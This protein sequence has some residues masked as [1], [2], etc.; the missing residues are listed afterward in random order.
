MN[1]PIPLFV[2]LC[3][4]TAAMSLRLHKAKARPPITRMGSKAGY[5]D[6]ILRVLGVEP[7]Q[8][9][10]RYLWCEPDD[11]VRL[12][13]HCYQDKILAEQ[14]AEIIRSWI[15]F[16]AR[17][18]WE[19]LKEEGPIKCPSSDPR[20]AARLL[21]RISV[22]YDSTLMRGGF[23]HPEKG[24][25]Y[26]AS[27]EMV[28]KRTES[29]VNIA[30]GVS[31]IEKDATKVDPREVARWIRVVTSNTLINLDPETW[32]N[33][34]RGG[35]TF[36]GI[37]CNP[38]S[39]LCSRIGKVDQIENA[40][41][42]GKA[43]SPE[44]SLPAG[45]VCYMD[46]PYV[47]TTPYAH[48]LPRSEVVRLAKAWSEA[49][50]IVCI[51]EAEPIGELVAEGWYE[52]EISWCRTGIGTRSFSKQQRE[53]LTMNIPGR[54]PGKPNRPLLKRKKGKVL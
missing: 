38:A 10:E 11:G 21:Y 25:R 52:R 13:L 26:G 49:G 48:D 19:Q 34:G 30:S 39:G 17:E 12:L 1:K 45:T 50:A 33:T 31:M 43:F 32:K 16:D 53:F 41:I 15:P 51:S 8:G 46:P 18:L 5:A 44:V 42:A 7:G 37:Y 9:A 35:D 36:G 28:A 14:A 27:R 54:H 4:G 24:G 29:M 20:E 47:N 22:E 2:E 40:A 6:T 23:V 3:A